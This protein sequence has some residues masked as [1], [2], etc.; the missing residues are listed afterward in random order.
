MISSKR[1]EKSYVRRLETLPEAARRLLLVA[2]AEPVGDPLLL[3]RACER[4]GIALSAVDATDGLLALDERVTFRHPLARSAVYRSAGGPERRAAHLAL[5]EVTNRDVDPDRRAWH[6]AAATAGPDEEVAR[7]LE[8][9]AGRAQARGGLA[10]AAA[11]PAARGRADGRSRASSRPSARSR[12]GQPGGGRVRCGSQAAGGRGGRTARRPRT[13][14]RGS[15][16]G[17]GRVRPEPRQR[18][19]AAAAAGREE[20]RDA[21]RPPLA[22]HVS[23]CVGR[24]A[25][26]RPAG[27]CGR[28]PARRL[29]RRGDCARPGGSSASARSAAG[30]LGVGLHRRA[31]RRG[32]RA[33]D[34]RS[35]RSRAP[36]SPR[37]RCSGGGCWR[38]GRRTW[39]G[40]TTALSRSARARCN[41]P[42]TSGALEVLAAADN[43]CGQAAAF[44]GDFATR[45][46]ADRGGRR[47]QGGDRDPHRPVRRD[48]ARG[49]PRPGGRGLRA[50]RRRHRASHR[51]RPGDRR[52]VRTAGRAPFS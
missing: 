30:R 3:Q 45:R 26:R 16:A 33:A 47:R 5:A 48:R 34:A 38:R 7:E 42:A 49:N 17:R 43:A 13:S 29:P 19:S 21:R 8:L 40:T 24:G 37:R 32:A 18:R 36:R 2:A 9:S 10:A 44:G 50:D 52:P 27:G 31:P 23:R 11:L 1:I 4:L 28:Q 46:A 6:L 39:S 14:P 51:R 25:V 20:A 35:L 41:S 22:R 12:P 15:A